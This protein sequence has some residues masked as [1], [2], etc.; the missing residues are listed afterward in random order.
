VKAVQDRELA[1]PM[2]QAH[3]ISEAAKEAGDEATA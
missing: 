1:K 3:I 2:R